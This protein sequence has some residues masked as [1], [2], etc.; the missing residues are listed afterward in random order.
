MCLIGGNVTSGVISKNVFANDSRFSH[1]DVNLF[2]L[3]PKLS[4]PSVFSIFFIVLI[5]SKS[6]DGRRVLFSEEAMC[7]FYYK[8]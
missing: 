7:S 6:F 1:V 5:R 4:S 2:D 8:V 3:D